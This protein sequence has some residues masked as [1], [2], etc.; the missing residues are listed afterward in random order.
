MGETT[1]R[2][3][4]NPSI[5]IPAD[6]SSVKPPSI[7]TWSGAPRRRPVGPGGRE[8]P[9][10][11][12]GGPCSCGPCR[13]LFLK[14]GPKCGRIKMAQRRDALLLWHCVEVFPICDEASLSLSGLSQE[15]H[16]V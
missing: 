15:A 7:Q 8:G 12:C 13:G 11:R 14:Q 4:P 2:L 5:I 16:H 10:S 6:T 1:V 9:R 3:V